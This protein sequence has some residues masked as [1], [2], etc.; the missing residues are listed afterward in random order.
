MISVHLPIGGELIPTAGASQL[1]AGRSRLPLRRPVHS[2][3]AEPVGAVPQVRLAEEMGIAA[4]L[5]F[6][7]CA[8]ILC[9]SGRGH[10]ART[11][12]PRCAI[13]IQVALFE[14]FDRARCCTESFRS[15]K[16]HRSRWPR[17]SDRASGAEFS[18]TPWRLFRDYSIHAAA[19]LLR[20][21]SR[22]A[23]PPFRNRRRRSGSAFMAIAV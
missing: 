12:I 5:R 16:I 18:R 14:T 21:M 7:F 22:A 11:G 10:E 19:M 23:D 13:E 9:D 17:R 8:A 4:N 2:C 20:W 3:R 6:P 1:R 15:K